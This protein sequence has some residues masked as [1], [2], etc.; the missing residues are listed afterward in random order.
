MCGLN[1]RGPRIELDGGSIKLL[2][3]K[4]KLVGVPK[5]LGPLPQCVLLAD[6][7]LYC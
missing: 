4:Y 7:F 3:E 2:L 6:L 1:V 5:S